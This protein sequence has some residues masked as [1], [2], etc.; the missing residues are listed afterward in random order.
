LSPPGAVIRGRRQHQ[1]SQTALA[2]TA[3]HLG[4][5][6]ELARVHGDLGLTLKVY[7]ERTQRRFG[8]EDRQLSE[9]YGRAREQLAARPCDLTAARAAVNA[10]VDAVRERERERERGT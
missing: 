10:Y 9:V 8:A 1:R 6:R 7:L 5:L 2:D 3:R 4:R